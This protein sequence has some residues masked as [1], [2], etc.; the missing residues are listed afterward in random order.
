[1]LML[2]ALKDMRPD[3][4]QC[5]HNLADWYANNQ[6]RY[7][8]YIHGAGTFPATVSFIGQPSP[9]SCNW[10]MAF[11]SMA[12]AAAGTAFSEDIY[13]YSAEKMINYLRTLQIFDPY[14][15]THYGAIR[16]MTQLTPWCYVRDALSAAWAFIEYYRLS[17]KEE[18]LER[19]KLWADWFYR[20]GCDENGLPLW[21]VEFAPSMGGT[22]VMHNNL[23]GN[24][25]GGSLNFFYQL[26]KA[27]GDDK[28][29]GGR[30]VD[31]AEFYL[32][33]VQQNNGFFVTIDKHT[34][35]TV[36]DP[37]K[38][39]H[40]TNDDFSSLGLLAAYRVTGERKYLDGI[41]KF[42]N[43]CFDAQQDNGSF[44]PTVA[45]IP[46]LLN[47]MLEAEG[48]LGPWPDV[49]LNGARRALEFMF[50]RQ[51]KGDVVP[52]LRG[53]LD[54]YGDGN[55]STRSSGYALIVLLKLFA[56]EERFLTAME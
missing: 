41:A 22:P 43:G 30:F 5:A 21:G 4:L 9:V 52:A 33:N 17:G 50:S 40:R 14:N 20:H 27:T 15:K 47:I 10:L 34:Q 31:F 46:V 11:G 35:Q 37:Q 2:E 3:G 54:E 24:F 1:M 7:R 32:A 12:M 45:G 36:D 49:W 39:L 13:A 28:Y 42:I 18:Y 53:G 23:L 16:E 19:A 55:L 44:E 26:Y 25:H 48:V 6:V 29:I 8:D 51:H 56:G 38:S